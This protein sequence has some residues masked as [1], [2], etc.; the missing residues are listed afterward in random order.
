MV[1]YMI[2]SELLSL[3]IMHMIEL[4]MTIKFSGIAHCV[5]PIEIVEKH[6]PVYNLSDLW[7]V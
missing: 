4:P 1:R 2:G 6:M 5:V 7:L 3:F